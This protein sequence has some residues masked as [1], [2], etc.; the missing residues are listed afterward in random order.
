M[1]IFLIYVIG[2]MDKKLNIHF[3][4]HKTKSILFPFKIKKYLKYLLKYLKT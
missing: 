3:D 4:E 2:S 1:R